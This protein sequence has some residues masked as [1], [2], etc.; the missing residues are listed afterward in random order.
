MSALFPTWVWTPVEGMGVDKC[1]LTWGAAPVPWFLSTPCGKLDTLKYRNLLQ[2]FT[3][4]IHI[5]CKCKFESNLII[6]FYIPARLTGELRSYILQVI[7]FRNFAIS[8]VKKWA[9]SRVFL[10]ISDVQ[11]LNCI[12]Y[13]HTNR[14]R[15][16]VSLKIKERIKS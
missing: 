2:E 15:A 5:S 6:H 4:Y 11:D 16:A 8:L 14:A 1:L 10:E 3:I 7:E 13:F 12:I 9:E